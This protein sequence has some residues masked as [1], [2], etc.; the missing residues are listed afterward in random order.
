LCFEV[1]PAFHY[2]IQLYRNDLVDFVGPVVPPLVLPAAFY[3][4]GET[5]TF[6]QKLRIERLR[7]S[8]RPSLFARSVNQVKKKKC[9]L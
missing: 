8:L 9:S 5:E 7:F 3:I 4:P 2:K 6:F 1:R